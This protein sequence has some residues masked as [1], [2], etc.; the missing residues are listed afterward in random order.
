M[1]VVSLDEFMKK[2]PNGMIV[3]STK[4][5]FDDIKNQLLQYGVKE[6]KI[7]NIGEY[8][9]QLSKQQ[10][11][12]LP[13]FLECIEDGE[14]FLD[15][16]SYDGETS[17]EFVKWY[18]QNGNN[19]NRPCKV[20][21]WEPGSDNIK[22]IETNLQ[23]YDIEYVLIRKGLWNKAGK[24]RFNQD[25][26]CSKI[27]TDTTASQCEFIEIEVDS[28]DAVMDVAATF[29]KMDIEGCEYEALLGAR[30]MI[31][32]NKPK[33][34]ISAYHKKDDIWKLPWLIHSINPEYKFYLRHYSFSTNETVL[35]AL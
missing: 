20:Y 29:I 30:E 35:Y 15:G 23:N 32:N 12:D 16:G 21:A 7:I 10:Y 18:K 22:K 25:L 11:F 19:K 14:V 31:R 24:F 33:L 5:V 28:I 6:D 34:A 27:I 4:W 13:E 3:I 2:Y 1:Q 17:L 8:Y 26:S 9:N